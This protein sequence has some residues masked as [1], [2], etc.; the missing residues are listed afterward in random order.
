MH[1]EAPESARSAAKRIRKTGDELD[2]IG[3]A[4]GAG[5]LEQAVEMGPDRGVPEMPSRSWRKTTMAAMLV[6]DLSS[7]A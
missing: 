1:C 5:F 7:A 4:L 3:L 2:E 6:G